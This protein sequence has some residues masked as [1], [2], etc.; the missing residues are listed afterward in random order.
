MVKHLKQRWPRFSVCW[1]DR[2]TRLGLIVRE[3]NVKTPYSA[4]TDLQ[5]MIVP[6][7]AG[8][9]VRASTGILG[10]SIIGTRLASYMRAEK[11]AAMCKIR[12]KPLAYAFKCY[13]ED[14]TRRGAARLGVTGMAKVSNPNGKYRILYFARSRKM[15][16]E[17]VP[18]CWNAVAIRH[19]TREEAVD[20]RDRL[21]AQ[22]PNDTF[23]VE[24]SN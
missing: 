3:Q 14:A 21:Q 4:K 12:N 9:A 6:L 19:D 15:W 23:M 11:Y 22:Y 17:F 16:V 5:R 24:G 2:H 1:I 8:C 18:A 7:I 10:H 13:S 20:R